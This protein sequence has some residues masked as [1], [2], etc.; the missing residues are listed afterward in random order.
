MSRREKIWLGFLVVLALG[1]LAA[2]LWLTERADRSDFWYAV[3]RGT[4]ADV[5]AALERGVD[6]N[7]RMDRG[8]CSALYHAVAR[9][10]ADVARLLLDEG[11]DP[12]LACDDPNWRKG[13]HLGKTPLHLA[14]QRL[15]EVIP[16]LLAHG[17]PVNAIDGM[18]QVP[19]VNAASLSPEEVALL[20]EH[21]AD[22]NIVDDDGRTP[23]QYVIEVGDVE[24]A[25]FLISKGAK[26]PDV[27]KEARDEPIYLAARNGKLEMV[28]VIVESGFSLEEANPGAL[29]VNDVEIVRYLL[30]AGMD[31]NQTDETGRTPLHLAHK[32]DVVQ[33]L[34][35]RDA[36]DVARDNQGNTA[37]HYNSY[38][39]DILDL[40]VSRGADVNA[41]NEAG[42]TPLHWVA[43]APSLDAAT[44]LVAHGANADAMD[45]EGAR[46]AD[47]IPYGLYRSLEAHELFKL[48]GPPAGRTLDE[49][50]S[51][52]QPQVPIHHWSPTMAWIWRR[53]ACG[54]P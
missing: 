21:G 10:M 6:V 42:E 38:N 46:P 53:M 54:L 45:A 50:L 44:A 49:V 43:R 51:L 5:A 39:S 41:V 8:G 2:G 12:S 17:A 11:A 20:L 15:P 18:G 13:A 30:D 48:L 24:M 28:K 4:Y 32:L 34:L 47:Y 33:L 26:A 36:D 1:I 23:L 37:I 35:E 14:V 16:D 9:R 31:P 29:A 52:Y 3:E 27:Y 40:L 25:R 19:L 7:I 22:L